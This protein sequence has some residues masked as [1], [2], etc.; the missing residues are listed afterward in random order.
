MAD[1]ELQ[2]VLSQEEKG[3]LRPE[4]ENAASWPLFWP[5]RGCASRKLEHIDNIGF[6]SFEKYI[7]LDMK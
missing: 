4:K 6:F 1:A 5:D 7:H 2:A 3:S